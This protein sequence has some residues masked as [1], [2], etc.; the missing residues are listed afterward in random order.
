[1]SPDSRTARRLAAVFFLGWVRLNYPILALFNLPATVAGIPLLYAFVFAAWI[2]IVA[3]VGLITLSGR[4][5]R[6]TDG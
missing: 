5:P 4:P 3:L 2:L 1:M 6:D